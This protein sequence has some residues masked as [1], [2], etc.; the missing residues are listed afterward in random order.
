LKLKLFFLPFSLLSHFFPFCFHLF[1]LKMAEVTDKNIEVTDRHSESAPQK[2]KKMA[3][4]SDKKTEADENNTAIAAPI[5]NY[6][7]ECRMYEQKYPEVDDLVVVEVKSIEEMGAYVALKEYNDIEGMILLSELSRRRIRSINKI[8]RVGRL[9]T[10]VVLRVDREKGYIDLSKRRVS[11]EDIA[12]CEE[13]YNKSKA[14][15][16]IMRHVAETVHQDVEPLYAQVAWPLYKKYGHAYDAFKQAISDN[17]RDKLFEGLNMSE[18]LQV[19]V[20]KNIKRRL[21]PQPVKVRADVEITCF[22]YEGIDAIKKALIKGEATSTVSSPIKI[23]LVAPPLYVVVT[24]AIQKDAGMKALHVAIEA[25]KKEIEI[26]KGDLHI[27]VEPRTVHERD[28][29]ELTSLFA[30]LAKENAE[31]NGDDDGEEGV[32]E[33][34]GTAVTDEDVEDEEGTGE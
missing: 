14:V 23:K 19:A 15:H 33:E 8:I 24:T 16:S 6:S 28:E 18:E 30:K 27:K 21:T 22:Q 25:I 20:V 12:K 11:E 9:E 13:K 10:V 29:K 32:G 31:V 26:F 7:V 5:A 34:N 3:E 4:V 1:I 17:E 2:N